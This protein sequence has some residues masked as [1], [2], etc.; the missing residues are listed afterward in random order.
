MK[1]KNCGAEV[2]EKRLFCPDCGEPLDVPEADYAAG[3]TAPIEEPASPAPDCLHDEP[4]APLGEDEPAEDAEDQYAEERYADPDELPAEGPAPAPAKKNRTAL[5]AIILAAAVVLSVCAMLIFGLQR[6]GDDPADVP[7]AAADDPATGNDPSTGEPAADDE[8]FV[9]PAPLPVND[10]VIATCGDHELTNE[11]FLFYYWDEF[12]YLYSQYGEYITYLMD[13]T[14]SLAAQEYETGVT[15]RDYL[16]EGAINTWAQT[17]TLG[18][19]ARI[20]GYELDAESRAELEGIPAQLETYAAQYGAENGEAYLRSS[21][22]EAVTLEGFRSYLEGTYLASGYV[23]SQYNGFMGVH[24]DLADQLKYNINVRHILIQPAEDTD[25]AK[26]TAKTEAERIYALW[27]ENPTED[28]FAALAGEHT[29]DPGSQETGGL[30]EDVKPGDM[31]TEFNDWCFAEGRA[32]GDHGIVETTHGYHIMYFSGF[33]ESYY[34]SAQEVAAGEDYDAWISPLLENV[35]F[36]RT[37][38]VIGYSR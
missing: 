25:E 8:P 12:Y 36:A 18:D 22:D 10:A 14:Q 31:V 17:M 32:V 15:W 16:T 9:D 6:D 24:A 1:C 34:E 4:T 28:N 5:V 37:E 3:E 38:A 27:Q 26:A 13:P 33:S 23:N 20:A 21:Y 7:P 29:Q 35:S 19:Q 11:T 2:P 30:Y